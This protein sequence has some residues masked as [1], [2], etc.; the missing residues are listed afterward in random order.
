MPRAFVCLI[1]VFVLLASSQASGHDDHEAAGVGS[2]YYAVI[3]D[4]HAT[5]STTDA[6]GEIFLTL[7]E[8]HTALSYYIVLDDL[9]GLK[10]NPA[11]RI[12]P[13]DIVGIHLHLHV[14]DTVGP[15]VLNIFGLATYN[16]PAEEDADRVIDYENKIISGIWDDGDAT[17]DPETGVPYL[18][19]FPLTSKPLTDWI[20]YLNSSELMVAIHTNESGF[21][22]MAIHGHISRV[23]PEP[24]TIAFAGTVLIFG[25]G[26]RFRK[27]RRW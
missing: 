7:N 6:I 10:E 26:S 8:D 16:M 3:D 25:F 18:P 5:P 12:E 24:V 11:D 20:D 22:T 1:S 4:F 14:P 13:D 23:V 9:L 21:P 2:Q 27:Q 15:H 19:F 17:I